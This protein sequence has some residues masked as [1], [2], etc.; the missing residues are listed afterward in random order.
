[1][2]TGTTGLVIFSDVFGEKSANVGGKKPAFGLMG[3]GTLGLFQI[4]SDILT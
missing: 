2:G 3:T 4:F 1:M